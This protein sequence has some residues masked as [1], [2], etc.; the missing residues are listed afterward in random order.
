LGGPVQ[1]L[2]GSQAQLAYVCMACMEAMASARHLAPN[3]Q[4]TLLQLLCGGEGGV[5]LPEGA[6]LILQ[7]AVTDHT[8]CLVIPGWSK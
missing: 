6:P 4:P 1:A 2:H 5:P 3:Y 8:L 7:Q